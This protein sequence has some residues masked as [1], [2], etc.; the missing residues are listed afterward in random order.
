MHAAA[1]VYQGHGWLIPGA[2]G[3]GKSTAAREGG[4]DSILSDEMVIVLPTPQRTQQVNHERFQSAYHLYST[5]FWSAGRVAPL[6][7]SSAPLSAL[8][9]PYKAGVAE[10]R[11]CSAADAVT[12][13]LRAVTIYERRDA[14]GSQRAELFRYACQV[15]ERSERAILAFPKQGPWRPRLPHSLHLTRGS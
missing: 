14:S 11:P 13:L 9:F 10:L 7:C 2:S 5:P 3:A 1:G 15:V 4:F 12:R 8:A 6:S